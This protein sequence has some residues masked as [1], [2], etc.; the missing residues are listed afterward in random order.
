M[1]YFLVATGVVA[2]LV[3]CTAEQK[4]PEQRWDVKVSTS[5]EP[6]VWV[7]RHDGSRQCDTPA[8]ITPESAARDLKS[9]GIMVYRF[10]AGNDGMMY[11]SVC[12][13]GTGATVDLEIATADLGKAERLGYKRKSSEN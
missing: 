4:K 1:R 2:S 6:R 12:G 5:G 8:Q 7:W 13:A 10:Q 9:R 11:P 3:A